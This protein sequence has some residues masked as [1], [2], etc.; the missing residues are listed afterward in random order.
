[1]ILVT[2]LQPGNHSCLFESSQGF[3]LVPGLLSF[4][5]GETKISKGLEILLMV[6]I[7]TPKPYTKKIFH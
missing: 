2:Q 3:F 7:T 5:F 1:M 4:P 6:N